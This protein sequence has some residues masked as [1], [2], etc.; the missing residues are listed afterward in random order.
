MFVGAASPAEATDTDAPKAGCAIR[1][2]HVQ[3]MSTKKSVRLMSNVEFL[4]VMDLHMFS[5]RSAVKLYALF[6][7]VAVLKD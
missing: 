4:I 3:E 6:D 5:R 7:H 1:D 2:F